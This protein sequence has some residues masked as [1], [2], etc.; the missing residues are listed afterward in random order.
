MKSNKLSSIE[1]NEKVKELHQE[2]FILH[3]KNN[4]LLDK[5]ERVSQDNINYEKRVRKLEEKMG[6][7]K[8]LDSMIKTGKFAD[9]NNMASTNKFGGADNF[10]STFKEKEK[11][12]NKYTTF[13]GT[14]NLQNTQNMQQNMELDKAEQSLRLYNMM[15]VD[16][17][18]FIFYD[19][20][21]IS[22]SRKFNKKL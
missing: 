3:E 9:N 15:Y 21:G 10:E 22:N 14:Q 7:D 2:N 6:E 11:D 16:K 1:T 4:E 5:L 13:S 17:V 20:L 18:N 8:N 12:K 19:N